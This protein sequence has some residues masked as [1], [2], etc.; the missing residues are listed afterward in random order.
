MRMGAQK[1]IQHFRLELR[2]KDIYRICAKKLKIIGD[3]EF[4]PEFLDKDR[5]REL[6]RLPQQ[7]NH[8]AVGAESLVTGGSAELAQHGQ[9][10][11][12][13]PFPIRLPVNDEPVKSLLGIHQYKAAC[14]NSFIGITPNLELPHELIPVLG[15]RNHDQTLAPFQA[16]PEIITYISGKTLLITFIKLDQMTPRVGIFK[17]IRRGRHY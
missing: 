10:S 5:L 8:L 3:Q 4:I 6:A 13:K 15:S 12:L 1:T 9:H 11:A 2:P 7:A 17:K 14:L 16:F